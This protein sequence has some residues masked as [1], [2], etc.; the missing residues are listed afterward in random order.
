MFPW[1]FIYLYWLSVGLKIVKLN[2]KEDGLFAYVHNKAQKKHAY[3][4]N[5]K[6]IIIR[7]TTRR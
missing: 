1:K 7:S 5:S 2:D 6:T 3:E 4:K